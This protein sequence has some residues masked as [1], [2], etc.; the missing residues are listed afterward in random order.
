MIIQGVYGSESWAVKNCDEKQLTAL[1]LRSWRRVLCIS[2]P[3]YKT[4]VWVRQKSG[5]PEENW[6]LEKLTKRTEGGLPAAR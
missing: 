4:N 5:I 1:A 2:W 6:L 3:E